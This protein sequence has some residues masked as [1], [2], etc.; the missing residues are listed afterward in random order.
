ME[1]VFKL[2]SDDGLHAR[3]A[4]LFVKTLA[5]FQSSVEVE[6]KGVKKNGKSIMSLMSLGAASGD[7]IKVILNGSDAEQALQAIETLFANKFAN[8]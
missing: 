8:S 4:G 1:K 3:P 2:D 5:P 7:E 6:L